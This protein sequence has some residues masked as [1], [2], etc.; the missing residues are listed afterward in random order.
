MGWKGTLR[1]LAAAQRRAEREAKRRQRELER[2]RK[3]LEKM[4]E[5]ELAAYEV[6]TFENYVD[7]LQSVHKECSEV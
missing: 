5:L 2:Q 3:Q 7:L 6:Q 4:E 1:S